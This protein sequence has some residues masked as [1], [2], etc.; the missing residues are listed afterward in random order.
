MRVVIRWTPSGAKSSRS[1]K[2]NRKVL[3]AR[4]ERI[5]DLMQMALATAAGRQ[6]PGCER[7]ATEV[8][9]HPL[10]EN[11][12]Q[13]FPVTP[14]DEYLLRR[15]QH[16]NPG[17]SETGFRHFDYPLHPPPRTAILMEGFIETQKVVCFPDG[18]STEL[19]KLR[20]ECLAGPVTMLRRMAVNVLNSGA[21]FPSLRRPIVAFTGLPFG[22]TG[23]LTAADRDQF[24][25]AY[26]VGVEEH[27]LGHRHEVLAREC[28]AHSGL[29]LDPI[30][31]VFEVDAD[32]SE[33]IITSLA[34]TVFPVARLATGFKA[35]LTEAQCPC[36]F[37]GQRLL[38][39]QPLATK[40][41]SIRVR[42]A[43]AGSGE[44]PTT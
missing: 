14:R 32:T 10:P 23:L 18:W 4:Q 9:S 1:P 5:R 7:I 30:Q 22:D 39:L 21:R 12:L 3:A 24:W 17:S 28:A 43:M 37:T 26:R 35:K 2:V 29:H 36:G 15:E 13:S 41:P 27:F 34:N 40:K 44:S 20:P 8:A 6:V 11:L 25:T 16:L 38:D 19:Q 42:V 33:L 31:A